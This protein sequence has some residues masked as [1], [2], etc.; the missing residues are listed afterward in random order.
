MP[1]D[2][3]GTYLLKRILIA[4]H[5]LTPL[6]TYSTVKVFI[7]VYLSTMTP[8]RHLLFP[9]VYVSD[10][11]HSLG[12]NWGGIGAQIQTRRAFMS[13]QRI[14]N[15]EQRTVLY[16]YLS[17][18]LFLSSTRDDGGNEIGGS[19]ESLRMDK[20]APLAETRGVRTCWSKSPKTRTQIGFGSGRI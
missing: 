4:S 16:L 20:V 5:A 2:H 13:Y 1:D 10:E 14:K 17:L 19:I 9:S 6:N 8:L 12:G 15:M 11:V 3:F 18:P 7:F